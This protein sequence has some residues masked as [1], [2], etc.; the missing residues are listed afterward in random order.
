MS[1]LSAPT[2]CG[3]SPVHWAI[4]IVLLSVAIG[5]GD[6]MA[7]PARNTQLLFSELLG[8]EN[9]DNNYYGD[10]MKFQQQQ[11]EQKQQRVPAFARKWPS[12]RDLL[13]T[14]DYDDF[15]VTQESEEQVAPSSRL[16]ARLHRLGDNGGG[17]ELRYNVVNDLTNMPSKKVLPGHPLKDHNT[18]KNVQYMSP[19]HFKICNMG[20]KRNAGF[21]SY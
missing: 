2:T 19:C 13:L 17:E 5:P 10:Q 9:E 6:A 14:V 15:G 21:N 4:V 18:K 7:R 11:Q 1:A 20:R 16:L 12:L 8:G 3:C